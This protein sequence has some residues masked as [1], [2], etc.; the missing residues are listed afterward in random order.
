MGKLLAER[1]QRKGSSRSPECNGTQVLEGR[2]LVRLKLKMLPSTILLSDG[3]EDA[4]SFLLMYC[5][6]RREPDCMRKN[7]EFGG[8]VLQ[9]RVL[10][11]GGAGFIGSHLVKRLADEDY[12]VVV[13]DNLSTGRLASIADVIKEGHATLVRGDVFDTKSAELACQDADM[14][15]HLAAEKSVTCSIAHPEETFR[16]NVDG[17]KTVF[18]AA[19]RAG[20]HSFTLAST[21]AVYGE[22]QCLPVGEGHPLVPL[23][24]YAESKIAAEKCC[25][26]TPNRNHPSTT[27]L[28]LFNV[29]GPG[30]SEVGYSGVMASLLGKV[31][32]G[33]PPV[34][35]GD[36]RQT[37]DFVHVQDVVNGIILAIEKTHT[38]PYYLNIGTG[39]GT[40]ILELANIIIGLSASK[41]LSPVFE[42]A[43][44]G[45]VIKSVANV[46]KAPKTPGF[47]ADV[48]IESGLRALVS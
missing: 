17:T 21:C 44:C 3:N 16:S 36:G 27:A 18:D 41:M 9:A 32:D 12:D 45:D 13:L 8:L 7:R 6:E 11:T 48:P 10:V 25:L 5:S 2:A 19:A 43:R 23:S 28:R 20:V 4:G 31:C 37:R 26:T 47:T 35:Y 1:S 22:A 29:Y 24:P 38:A 46:E 15:V 33:K 34:I 30:Q 39:R 40:T 14:V 42:A